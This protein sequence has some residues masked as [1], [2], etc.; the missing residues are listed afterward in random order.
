MNERAGLVEFIQVTHFDDVG[1]CFDLGHAH[2]MSK[3]AGVFEILKATFIPP[4]H[5]NATVRDSHL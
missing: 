4:V 1:I 5:D 2:I 3:V